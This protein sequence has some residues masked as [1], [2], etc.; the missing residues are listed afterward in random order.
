MDLLWGQKLYQKL[1]FVLV[2]YDG[3]RSILVSTDLTPTAVQIIEIY[4]LSLHDALPI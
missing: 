1:R 2:E 3:Q 4:T